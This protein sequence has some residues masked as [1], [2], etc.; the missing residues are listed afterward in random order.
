MAILAVVVMLIVSIGGSTRAVPS[1]KDDTTCLVPESQHL[2]LDQCANDFPGNNSI[3]V[4]SSC[5]YLF[6]YLLRII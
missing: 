1:L 5:L 3:V 6:V 2:G 4:Q